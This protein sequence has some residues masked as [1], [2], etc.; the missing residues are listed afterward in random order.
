MSFVIEFRRAFSSIELINTDIMLVSASKQVTSVRESDFSA[1]FYWDF[2]ESFQSLLEYVHHSNFVSKTNYNMETR[3]MESQTKSLI[4]E[5]LTNFK[6]LLLIVPNSNSLIN[7]ASTDQV[8]LYT[9]I[10]TVDGSWMEWENKVLILGIIRWSFDVYGH[11]HKL[12]ILSCKD[13]S[14]FW[15]W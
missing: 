13:Q 12:I 4:L 2:F 9:D 3:W 10:H 6:S 14:I 7:R 1:T 11:F 5:S 15:A 8:F